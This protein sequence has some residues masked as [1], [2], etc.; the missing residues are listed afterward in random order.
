M[1]RIGLF[2]AFALCGGTDFLFAEPLPSGSSESALDEVANLKR[3]VKQK[4]LQIMRLRNQIDELVE[5]LEQYKKNP[6]QDT[7][8]TATAD[9]EKADPGG[10]RKVS[11]QDIEKEMQRLLTRAKRLELQ[12]MNQESAVLRKQARA[13]R[14]KLNDG[15]SATK[16]NR[17]TE[18][19]SSKSRLRQESNRQTLSELRREIRKLRGGGRI[20]EA[21]GLQRQLEAREEGEKQ[22]TKSE[23]SDRKNKK[24]LVKTGISSDNP[25]DLRKVFENIL[26][27]L[28]GL[29]NDVGELRDE[30]G[31]IREQVGGDR[32][33]RSSRLRGSS[34]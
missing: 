9:P 14:K 15:V 32:T 11:R 2:V 12:G 22:Q 10:K 25:G 28:Q 30:L 4:D 27:Q 7:K 8:A 23:K 34:R 18:T 29:R 24:D 16:N 31:Q 13:L 5:Q 26:E 1:I 17:D 21:R 20:R 3:L 6:K 33:R 19:S